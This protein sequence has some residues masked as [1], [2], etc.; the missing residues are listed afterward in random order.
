MN[1]L[2]LLILRLFLGVTFIWIGVY[3]WQAPEAWGG[4]IQPWAAN[5]SP[6]P[7]RELMLG[8]ALL[9]IGLGIWLLIGKT[10]WIPALIAS[11]H[12]AIVLLTSGINAI[13]VR[14]IGLLGATLFLFLHYKGIS[15]R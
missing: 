15:G 5:L 1:N 12:L 3:I 2:P 6:I 7:M 14:D 10:I 9:D 11:L 8:T 13:T 4:Y